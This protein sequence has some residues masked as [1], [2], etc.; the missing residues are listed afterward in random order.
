[1]KKKYINLLAIMIVSTLFGLSLKNP[2]KS[3]EIYVKE[4]INNTKK[5][6]SYRQLSTSKGYKT[7]CPAPFN[8]PKTIAPKTTLDGTKQM[9]RIERGT[10]LLN[11]N[12]GSLEISAHGHKYLLYKN[13]GKIY[14]ATDMYEKV[15]FD[16]SK[17]PHLKDTKPINIAIKITDAVDDIT[18][19]PAD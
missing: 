1:M 18:I 19:E 10:K 17:C 8:L 3:D 2:F 5:K 7:E 11:G 9:L 14:S 16:K 15:Y 4:I 6:I 12:C 13:D